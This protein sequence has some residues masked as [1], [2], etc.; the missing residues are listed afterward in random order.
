MTFFNLIH[1]LNR[2]HW[3]LLLVEYR[4]AQVRMRE[5]YDVIFRFSWPD[6]EEGKN[7][8]NVKQKPKVFW[9]TQRE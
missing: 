8:K 2:V 3:Q 7:A 4:T 5:N 9:L 6:Q 1:A